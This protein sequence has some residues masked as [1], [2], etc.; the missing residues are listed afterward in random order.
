M[1][2]FLERNFTLIDL[3][4]VLSASACIFVSGHWFDHDAVVLRTLNGNRAPVYTAIAGLF[5]TI[6]GFALTAMSIVL[7]FAESPRLIILRRS[8]HW[9]TLWRVFTRGIRVFLTVALTAI[10]GLIFDKEGLPN[11]LAAYVVITVA[12]LGAAQVYR[13]VWAFE[14]LVFIMTR[15]HPDASAGGADLQEAQTTPRL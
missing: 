13:V 8:R 9:T 4:I 12:L 1:R 7:A 14:K 10:A 3:L 15:S 11:P 2:P 5:G 6:F